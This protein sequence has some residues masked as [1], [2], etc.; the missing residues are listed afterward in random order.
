LLRVPTNV[1]VGR[2]LSTFKVWHGRL[3]AAIILAAAEEIYVLVLS[4]L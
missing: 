4:S 3:P 1:I 2:A